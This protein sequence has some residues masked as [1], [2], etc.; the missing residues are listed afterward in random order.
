MTELRRQIVR[1][2]DSSSI[3]P[4]GRWRT[5]NPVTLFDSKQTNE[6]YQL[7]WDISSTGTGTSSNYNENGAK[8]TL[9]VSNLTAG[10][11]IRQSKKRSNYQAGKGQLILATFNLISN[12]LGITKEVG[13]FDDDNG[14]FFRVDGTNISI[15]IKSNVTGTPVDTVINQGSWN[16]DNFDGTGPSKMIFD[17]AKSQILLIDFEWLGVGRVRV[18]TVIDGKIYYAHA[19]NNA[20]NLPSVYMS[21]PN[22]PI[23]YSIE[24]D[25]TGPA[26]SMDTI[27]ASVSTEGGEDITGILRSVNTGNSGISVTSSNFRAVLGIQQKPT[28]LD[29]VIKIEKI[30]L[31]SRTS[32]DQF[33]WELLLNPTVAG[34]FTYSNLVTSSGVQYAKGGGTNTVTGGISLD[35]GFIKDFASENIPINNA[36]Q[37]GS[38]IAGVQDSIVLCV[39]NI[40]SN[41][42]LDASL[43]YRESL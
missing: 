11:I 6:A 2:D 3:D 8:T 43:T 19:F 15:V 10:K 32:N 13:Y 16:I 37:L 29:S 27:C 12:D 24:N 34:T 4:F 14:I 7:F 9:S 5:S 25:G 26:S 18:G 17:V 31:M 42:T 38:T 41:A 40:T 23:R 30:S 20:N 39:Y 36:Y 35:S 22:L 33:R 21:K 1:A 28:E